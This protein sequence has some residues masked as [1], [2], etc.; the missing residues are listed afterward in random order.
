MGVLR[1][2]KIKNRSDDNFWKIGMKWVC[3]AE[4]NLKMGQT[5]ENF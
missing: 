1:R 5:I 3:Y 4:I 2:N